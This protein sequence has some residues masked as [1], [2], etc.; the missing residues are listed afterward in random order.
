ML[1]VR[2]QRAAAAAQLG[3]SVAGATSTRCRRGAGF[4]SEF[5]PGN[6]PVDRLFDGTA[7]DAVEQL[8]PLLAELTPPWS[9]WFGLIPGREV[10]A[11]E[12]GAVAEAW[13]GS[14]RP[15]R[16]TSIVRT[17]RSRSINA[18]SI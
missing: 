8:A 17:S 3:K 12:R 10:G 15:C 11:I 2:W 18:S 7:L 1:F 4:G 13:I 16:P 6:N 5:R 9:Q 14:L